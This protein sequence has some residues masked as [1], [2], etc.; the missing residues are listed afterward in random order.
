MINWSTDLG[1]QQSPMSGAMGVM[2]QPFLAIL[3]KASAY[4]FLVHFA[5][6]ITV[7]N[8]V[9]HKRGCACQFSLLK[10]QLQ[11]VGKNKTSRLHQLCGLGSSIPDA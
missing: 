9:T 11:S 1:H 8:P 4:G 3:T 6:K 7:K 10:C 5:M 2:A